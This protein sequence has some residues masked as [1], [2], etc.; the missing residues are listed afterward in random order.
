MLVKDFCRDGFVVLEPPSKTIRS[1]QI[2]SLLGCLINATPTRAQ[3]RGNTLGRP[4]RWHYDRRAPKTEEE[5]A[6]QREQRWPGPL[7]AGAVAVVTIIWAV[8]DFTPE[9]GGVALVPGSHLARA[10]CMPGD[11]P[12]AYSLLTLSAGDA[13]AFISTHVLHRTEQN[14]SG[15]PRR[16]WLQ[17]WVGTWR[18]PTGSESAPCALQ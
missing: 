16:S 2:A 5:R 13:V 14:W 6:T 8:D 17:R 15:V 9:N 10:C 1:C 11:D 7:A 3:S 4:G 18:M 12:D